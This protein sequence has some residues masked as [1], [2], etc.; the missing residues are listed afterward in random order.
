MIKKLLS[1]VTLTALL[2]T[3]AAVMP[4]AATGTETNV[5]YTFK[6]SDA[7]PGNGA[8]AYMKKDEQLGITPHSGSNYFAMPGSDDYFAFTFN[9]PEGGDDANYILSFY[10]KT[11]LEKS[12][13]VETVPQ[14]KY[15]NGATVL[16][17][18]Y[19]KENNLP[20]I[21]SNNTE[22]MS[23]MITGVQGEKGSDWLENR[24]EFRVPEDCNIIKIY[25]N[26]H[27]NNYQS[28]NNS[29][30]NFVKKEDVYR[31]VD[32]ITIEKAP[33][34]LIR[35]GGFDGVAY[36]GTAENPKKE[37]PY[38]T[39]YNSVTNKA[40]GALE[41]RETE[42]DPYL[43]V[44]EPRDWSQGVRANQVYQTV[45]LYPGEYLLSM[46]VSMKRSR[47]TTIIN[48][49]T[50]SSGNDCTLADIQTL[51]LIPVGV[52]GYY[53]D[54]TYSYSSYFT[55]NTQKGYTLSIGSSSY[56]G[57]FTFDNIRIIPVEKGNL[58]FGTINYS[59]TDTTNVGK[60]DFHFEY[61]PAKDLK[62]GD[63]VRAFGHA[64]VD[65]VGKT[66]NVLTSVYKVAP[67]GNRVLTEVKI[68][69]AEA[70]KLFAGTE[71][72]IPTLASGEKAEVKAMVLNSLGEL[73]AF[74][75]DFILK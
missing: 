71:V 32:T 27:F 66:A 37:M 7:Y 22:N 54:K 20:Y 63:K 18:Q 21:A 40:G 26:V 11:S 33:Y 62:A 41:L 9:V 56:Y 52:D 12:L 24:L 16:W 69:N 73:K 72:T 50:N 75:K 5:V 67:G 3:I 2:F 51:A 10:A 45:Y 39:W 49:S 38:S 64:V 15:E 23:Y 28:L 17:E 46:D 8:N 19:R 25:F 55:V 1:M 70:G 36:S 31:A 42:N 44:V 6:E 47:K 68:D 74:G 65:T 58:Q 35:N 34:N 29:F 30:A 60:G 43:Y 53:Y 59:A 13:C 48:L 61:T 4:A 14:V 57:T